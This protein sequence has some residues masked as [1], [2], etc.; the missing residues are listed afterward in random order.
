M[1]VLGQ[2]QEAREVAEQAVPFSPAMVITAAGI[3]AVAGTL[4]SA[5]AIWRAKRKGGSTAEGVFAGAGV[6]A[7]LGAL[8]IWLARRAVVTTYAHALDELPPGADD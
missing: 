4:V 6:A 3:A 1:Y 8:L 5:G 7:G 2:S